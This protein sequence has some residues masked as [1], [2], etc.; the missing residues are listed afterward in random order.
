MATTYE[1]IAKQ[2][3]GSAAASVTFSSI[4]GTYTDLLFAWSVRGDQASSTYQDIY[5]GFNS[6]TANFTNRYLEGSGSGASSGTNLASGRYLGVVPASTATASTFSNGECYIPNY[7]GS[8]NK[9][10]SSTNAHETNA[11]A[12][13]IT[14][15]AGLWSNTSAITSVE[16]GTSSTRNFVSGSSFYLYGITKA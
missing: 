7:A 1:L 15:V 9:S 10:F 16:F 2:I 11:T 12:A 8:T 6:S 14:V 3:L 5:I 4:P 13:Y